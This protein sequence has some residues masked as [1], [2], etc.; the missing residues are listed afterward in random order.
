MKII[1]LDFDGVIRVPA[2]NDAWSMS[3]E[4]QFSQDLMKQLASL[5]IQSGAQIVVSS[6]WRRD[7][8]RD[9]IEAILTPHLARLL[10]DD[11]M[12]P[13][14]GHRWN[15]IQRW[16]AEHPATS[17]FVIL[18]DAGFLFDEAPPEI[19]GRVILCASRFGI[20]PRLIEKSAEMLA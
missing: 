14:R 2:S 1:F 3:D 19:A 6:D 5:C 11:W 15:E 7:D 8:N 16:L 10:H 4:M 9:E 18:D 20:V 12:T 13:I 17:R